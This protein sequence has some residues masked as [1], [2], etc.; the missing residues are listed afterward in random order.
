MAHEP[1]AIVSADGKDLN[2]FSYQKVLTGGPGHLVVPGLLSIPSIDATL[3]M[4]REYK[5][6]VVEDVDHDWDGDLN[7]ADTSV[8]WM[9][10]YEDMSSDVLVATAIAAEIGKGLELLGIDWQSE[11]VE[12]DEDDI[13]QGDDGEVVPENLIRCPPEPLDLLPE[14]TQLLDQAIAIARYF[15]N[16][17]DDWVIDEWHAYGEACVDE[18]EGIYVT[19]LDERGIDCPDLPSIAGLHDWNDI[20]PELEEEG[21]LFDGTILVYECTSV[22]RGI[23]DLILQGTKP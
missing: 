19:T 1:G 2:V 10:A 21:Y 16:I 7:Y 11:N 17:G 6:R 5:R 15:S 20:G 22:L 23:V 8:Q 18:Q 3:R 14:I 13:E 12:D 4:H 9:G